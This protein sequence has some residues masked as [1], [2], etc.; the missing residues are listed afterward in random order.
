MIEEV[1]MRHFRRFDDQTVEFEPGVNLIEGLNN[2]GKSTILYAIEYG[3]FGYVRG[4]K[5]KSEYTT[6]EQPDAGVELVF[7][8]ND[9][10]RYRLMRFHKLKKTKVSAFHTETIRYRQRW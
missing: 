8:G 10:R 1:R 6:R 3:L 2:S 9:G 4:F 7:K 5:K